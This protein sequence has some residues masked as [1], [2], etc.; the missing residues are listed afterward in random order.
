V[1]VVL[2]RDDQDFI[3]TNEFVLNLANRRDIVNAGQVNVVYSPLV[4]TPARGLTFNFTLRREHRASNQAALS[5]D[6]TIGK[7]GF[8]FK[9]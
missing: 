1:A 5:Y 2:S 7:A 4:F 6:D 3:G 9:F 8:I